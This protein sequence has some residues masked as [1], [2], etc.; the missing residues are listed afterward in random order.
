MDKDGE[1]SA[2]WWVFEDE[3]RDLVSESA[4]GGGRFRDRHTLNAAM[5]AF[6]A[7]QGPAG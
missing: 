7:P 6:A 5:L 1:H 4:D 3:A 2:L